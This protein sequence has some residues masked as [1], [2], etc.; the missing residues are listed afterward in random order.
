MKWCGE[1]EREGMVRDGRNGSVNG[2]AKV[3]CRKG[4]FHRIEQEITSYFF[5]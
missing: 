1:R 3:Q 5:K 4:F 2:E